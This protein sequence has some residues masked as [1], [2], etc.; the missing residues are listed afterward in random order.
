MWLWSRSAFPQ[1]IPISHL[2]FWSWIWTGSSAESVH[3]SRLSCRFAVQKLQ[4]FRSFSV[5]SGKSQILQVNIVKASL[6]CVVIIYCQW[7]DEWKRP[8]WFINNS[9]CWY[10]KSSK[11][12][13]EREEFET[14]ERWMSS[15]P[16]YQLFKKWSTKVTQFS[17][18][19][20]HHISADF[21]IFYC[22]SQH[23]EF[24]KSTI[25]FL[26][27]Q[28]YPLRNAFWGP[29]NISAV[30]RL[31]Y[32]TKLKIWSTRLC[33]LQYKYRCNNKW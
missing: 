14:N 4:S 15:R 2:R 11:S 32:D 19:T 27:N 24:L 30:M 13:R 3:E 7:E 17:K 33:A 8:R 10:V 12:E 23:E 9:Q 31:V 1:L 21:F 20:A 5:T 29:C 28:Y 6:W 22:Q 25:T 18:K 16:F 26:N